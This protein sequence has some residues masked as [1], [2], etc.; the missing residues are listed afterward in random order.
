MTVMTD[1]KYIE[2]NPQAV[3][4]KPHIAGRRITVQQIA[5]WHDQM[6]YSVDEIA[7]QYDL[8]LAE[9]YAALAYYYDHKAELDAAL[10]E[11]EMFVAM[12]RQQTPS[13]LLQKL[14]GYSGNAAAT[15]SDNN[16]FANAGFGDATEMLSC[17]TAL[18]IGCRLTLNVK[19][20]LL[21]QCLKTYRESGS[22]AR[23]K[24]SLSGGEWLIGN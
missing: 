3:G 17:S 1:Y 23:G 19:V 4:G 16:S 18:Q 12:L 24:D 20:R 9:I 7:T 15:S 14:Y 22:F 2:T 5:I 10:A 6:G 8:T 13:L 11:S 21:P